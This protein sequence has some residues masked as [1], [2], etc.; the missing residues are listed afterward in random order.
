[1]RRSGL[2]SRSKGLTAP[3]IL[4]QYPTPRFPR[5][6]ISKIVLPKSSKSLVVNNRDIPELKDLPT[7]DGKRT[8]PVEGLG[9]LV[10]MGDAPACNICGSLM[11]R[12]GTCY[13]CMTC[14]ST[15]GCS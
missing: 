4:L 6:S 8:D 14:G 9:E 5:I 2:R 3:G 7:T 1:M 10:Q 11:V 12:S 13:R 15:S